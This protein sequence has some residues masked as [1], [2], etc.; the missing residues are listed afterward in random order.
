MLNH[1]AYVFCGEIG[2]NNN[3]TN[4]IELLPIEEAS[5]GGINEVWQLIEVPEDILS[6]RLVPAVVAINDTEIAILGGY[7]TKPHPAL[8]FKDVYLFNTKNKRVKRVAEN[9][10]GND[11]SCF[12]N[13]NMTALIAHEEVV[14]LAGRFKH[15]KPSIFTWKKG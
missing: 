12:T 9:S 15:T 5:R 8:F 7:D 6:C 13:N 4:S 1:V 11:D 2:R 10:D 3:T 14:M